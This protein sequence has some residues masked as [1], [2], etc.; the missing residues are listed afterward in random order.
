MPD[1]TQHQFYWRQPWVYAGTKTFNAKGLHCAYYM[2]EITS[3]DGQWRA[4]SNPGFLAIRLQFDLFGQVNFW[5]FAGVRNMY[6][7]KIRYST[8]SEP[9]PP[10]AWQPP[11]GCE[12]QIFF[13]PST[14]TPGTGGG[15]SGG[16]PV[17]PTTPCPVQYV[18]IE[19]SSNGGNTWTV[20]WEGWVSVC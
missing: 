15:N 6:Y 2:D 17:N 12:Y 19:I 5:K 13:D 11:A 1:G 8:P 3:A 9:P 10:P 18:V 7:Y 20:W 4:I 16:G 14:C